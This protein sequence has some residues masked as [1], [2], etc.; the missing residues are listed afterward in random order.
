MTD[1]LVS[2]EVITEQNYLM[3]VQTGLS[4]Q[5]ERL[6]FPGEI[7]RPIGAPPVLVTSE[8]NVYLAHTEPLLGT[9]VAVF[10]ETLLPLDEVIVLTAAP[11][12]KVVE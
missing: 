5:P 10:E 7:P 3:T 4:D 11:L 1:T 12:E 9:H 8:T 2:V 6:E